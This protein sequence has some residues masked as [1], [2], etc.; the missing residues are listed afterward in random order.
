MNILIPK[1]GW[2]VWD[3][4]KGMQDPAGSMGAVPRPMWLG[5]W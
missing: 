5:T 4:L 2:T 1:K 3:V